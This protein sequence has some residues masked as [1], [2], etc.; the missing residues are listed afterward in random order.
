MSDLVIFQET[1]LLIMLNGLQSDDL[2]IVA[3][4]H[5]PYACGIAARHTYLIHLY[6][7]DLALSAHDH[8]LIGLQD[9]PDGDDAAVPLGG[10]QG[11]DAFPAPVGLTVIVHP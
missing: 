10:L 2:V 5:Y 1:F 6:A 9:L 4:V 3:Q 11:D 7:Y 8:Q